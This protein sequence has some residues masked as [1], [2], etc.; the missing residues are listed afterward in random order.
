MSSTTLLRTMIRQCQVSILKSLFRRESLPRPKMKGK[1][2]TCHTPLGPICP[3]IGTSLRLHSGHMSNMTGEIHGRPKILGALDVTK[4]VA[5][6]T[7]IGMKMAGRI[8]RK[9]TMT[10]TSLGKAHN[11]RVEVNTIGNTSTTTI[12]P[13]QA[14]MAMPLMEVLE[15][16]TTIGAAD[17]G[18]NQVVPLTSWTGRIS[19]SR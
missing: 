15:Q 11:M 10:T 4:L 13:T 5:A 9:L 12:G 7:I 6:E 8:G 1:P 16:T 14:T 19:R 2:E 18:I 17:P 3:P